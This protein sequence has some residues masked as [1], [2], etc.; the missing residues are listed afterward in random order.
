MRVA[1]VPA[2][3]EAATIGDTLAALRPLVDR[4]I[5]ADDGSQDL[6]SERAASAGAVVIRR[7]NRGGKGAAAEA[8]VRAA[9]G[10]G[11]TVVLLAD[12]DLGSS[13][14]S[15]ATLLE[16]VEADAPDAPDMA[17]GVL[18]AQPG[19]GFGLVRDY[20]ADAIEAATHW[21]PMAP[22]SG[23]RALTASA[24]AVCLP[25][26]PGFGLETAMTID[27]LRAGLRV[28]EIPVS[29]THR[30]LGRGLR[31]ALHRARQGVQIR[32]ALQDRR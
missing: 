30:P 13:A 16:T 18:P 1:V 31:G 9:L 22:L 6:T 29:A 12:A 26:A 25:F 24:V 11:G 8:G 7:T 10:L 17:I 28:H 21:R 20:A 2:Y 4:I 5:V 15:L 32:S 19:G 14:A 27:A 23:Q 3:Q